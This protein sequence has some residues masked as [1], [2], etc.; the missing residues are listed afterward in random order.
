[1]CGGGHAWWGHVWQ[2]GD[3]RGRGHAWQGACMVGGMR[4]RGHEWHGEMATAVVGTHSC[5]LRGLT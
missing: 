3:M 5:L 2:G 4:G 1:M